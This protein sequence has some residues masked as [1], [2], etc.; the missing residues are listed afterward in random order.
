MININPEDFI[1]QIEGFFK[2][3][4]NSYPVELDEVIDKIIKSDKSPAEKIKLLEKEKQYYLSLVNSLQKN[5]AYL[6]ESL[7]EK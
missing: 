1:K 2:F 5:I 3:I 4:T 7:E 6:E